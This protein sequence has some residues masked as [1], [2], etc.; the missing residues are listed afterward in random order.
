M[1][2]SGK[3]KEIN[4]SSSSSS[5]KERK[6]DRAF[7]VEVLW[8]M[9]KSCAKTIDYRTYRQESNLHWFDLKITSRTAKLVKKLR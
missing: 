3:F 1:A 9:Q 5:T 6:K 8:P 7:R 4:D 2:S